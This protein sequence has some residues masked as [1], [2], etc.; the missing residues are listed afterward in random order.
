MTESLPAKT[1][2]E[3]KGWF[4]ALRESH[5]WPAALDSL[6]NMCERADVQHCER[7]RLSAAL[8]L[9]RENIANRFGY[10][11]TNNLDSDLLRQIDEALGD[12]PS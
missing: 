2:D 4:N 6:A 10:G 3:W 12:D 11:S 8:R 5:D 9:A 1:H 7:D